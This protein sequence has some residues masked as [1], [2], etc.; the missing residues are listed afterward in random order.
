MRRLQFD[1]RRTTGLISLHPTPQTE[2]PIIAC[3]QPGELVFRHRGAQI[4]PLRTAESQKGI[5]HLRADRVHAGII[6]TSI[7]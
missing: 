3:L 5:R 2:A 1:Q 4:V 7:T 6:R